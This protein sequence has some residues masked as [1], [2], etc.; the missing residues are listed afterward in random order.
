[1]KKILLSCLI[2]FTLVMSSCN[3]DVAVP[4]VVKEEI[5]PA[6][7]EKPIVPPVEDSTADE[8]SID[9]TQIGESSDWMTIDQDTKINI[10]NVA[11]DEVFV[12]YINDPSSS[13][14]IGAVASR[15]V[16]SPM[17]GGFNKSVTGKQIIRTENGVASFSG[18]D[19]G[20]TGETTFKIERLKVKKVETVE[21]L[22][23]TELSVFDYNGYEQGKVYIPNS[24]SSYY[25]VDEKVFSLNVNQIVNQL[26]NEYGVDDSLQK[27]VLT[28]FTGYYNAEIEEKYKEEGTVINH[29]TRIT[30]GFLVKEND[31]YKVMSEGVFDFTDIG[32]RVNLYAGLASD[33]IS[34]SG[35][36][37][38]IL[39]VDVLEL[40]KPM[41]VKKAD[42]VFGLENLEEGKY[43]LKVSNLGKND[44]N[45]FTLQDH[46]KTEIRKYD[47]ERLPN[48]LMLSY[49]SDYSDAYYYYLGE[50][51]GNVYINNMDKGDSVADEDGNYYTVELIRYEDVPEYI[52]D[53]SF[54]DYKDNIAIG[55]FNSSSS[56]I[57][58]ADNR[59]TDILS[60]PE[61]KNVSSGNL[62]FV[63]TNV[64]QGKK[65]NVRF[66][67]I[68]NK[69]PVEVYDDKKY[70]C[71]IGFASTAHDMVEN[72]L[73][74]DNGNSNISF[75]FSR[76]E[77][78]E[79]IMAVIT[80]SNR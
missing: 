57:P 65:Y 31:E 9:T 69:G 64:P 67:K 13:R 63:M 29:N 50:I 19:A 5:P 15:G 33:N 7:E 36:T 58:E 54:F 42:S 17:I 37:L 40:N 72:N 47:G 59:I 25:Y 75:R 35:L 48:G 22:W 49:L 3:Q 1:M 78:G 24:M 41:D 11:D 43:V 79:C 68:T 73:G 52:K 34:G 6:N 60:L 38:R 27:V 51:S 71:I 74:V 30:Y 18:L 61:G 45:S 8:I 46:N 76:L 10:S 28:C 55:V 62:S 26:K 2:I 44:I 66:I 12:M 32:N 77:D 23:N 20:V 39:P 14:S 53:K 4:P 56:S 16:S 21:D 80:F 70:N